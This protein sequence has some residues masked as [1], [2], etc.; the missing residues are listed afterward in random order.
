MV[1][2]GAFLALSSVVIVTPGQDMALTLRNALR[3]RRTGVA[4][5]LGITSGT[6]VWTVAASVGVAAV[7]AS[8]APLFL[9]LRLAGALYLLW[10]G[11]HA[12]RAAVR[13]RRED[14]PAATVAAPPLS[15]RKAYRQGLLSN[16]GNPKVAVFF[17]SFLP[18]FARPGHGA[19]LALLALGFL[20]CLLGTVWLTVYA[21]AV[22]RAGDVLRRPFVR[23]VVDAV[24]GAVLVAFGFRL[25]L[26]RR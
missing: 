19:F 10:L 25:A 22:A 6:A 1:H 5:G 24:S 18:Q 14:H 17:T 16:L 7:I 23:R 20:F 3:G 21:L 2:V 13:R 11:A 15:A 26:E 12:L 4:T 9:A 8:S